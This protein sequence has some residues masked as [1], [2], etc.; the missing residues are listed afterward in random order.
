MI[1][2]YRNIAILVFGLA[3]LA[4]IAQE[5][6]L[7]E[8]LQEAGENNPGL[9]AAFQQYYAALEKIPQSGALP[10]PQLSFGAFIKPV[11]TRLGPQ[12]AKISISQMFPW[13]GKLGEQEKA[14]AEKAQA[15]YQKFLSLKNELYK[16]VK[17]KYYE[18]Y[19][20]NKAIEIT[21]Q[22][23]EVLNSLK[24]VTKRNYESGKS[25]MS[26][27]LRLRVDIREHENKLEDLEDRLETLTVDFNLLMNREEQ[28]D[29]FIPKQLKL[30]TFNI[31][32]MKDSIRTNPEI[33]AFM[34]EEKSLLH[35]YEVAKKQGYPDLS[36]GLDYV[37]VGKRQDMNVPNSG[38]NI[39]MP[40]IGIRIPINRE[41]YNSM[42]KEKQHQLNAVRFSKQERFNRL[43]SAYEDAE[44]DYLKGVRRVDLYKKQVEESKSIFKLLETEYASDGKDFYEMLKTRLLVLEYELKLEQA[45]AAQNIA[46]A[47]LEY[48]TGT[49]NDSNQLDSRD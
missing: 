3:S 8:Y 1:K 14:F 24:K 19:K 23:L 12:Q 48:L 29:V 2:L 7:G 28:Q 21:S 35:Q 15:K 34:H 13:F 42:K 17:V 33:N 40:M 38:Q 49:S 11:E 45:K 27:V 22:N 5:K 25:E 47:K 10:D 18:L 46:A 20:V 4:T 44:D 31:S 30:D 16:D 43:K 36:V 32:T 41:K 37:F 39:V 6:Q 9:Q 26:D